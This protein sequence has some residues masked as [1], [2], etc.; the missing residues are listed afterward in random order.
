MA[1]PATPTTRNGTDSETELRTPPANPFYAVQYHFG[2]LL[3]VQDFQDEQGYHR[4]K[5]R[6]HN[7][8]LH[9]EGVVWGMGVSLPRPDDGPL[10]GEIEVAP[11][12]GLDGA[13]QELR[14]ETPM[15]VDV[16]RWF[17]EQAEDEDFEVREREEAWGLAEVAFDAHVLARFRAC[18]TRPVPAMSEPC[19]GASSETAYSRLSETVELVLVPGPPPPPDS[20][21]YHRLRLL[22]ALA[23][24][25]TDEEGIVEA[26]QAVLDARTDILELAPEERPEAFLEALRRFAAL[27]VVDRRPADE[28]GGPSRHFPLGGRPPLLLAS[29]TDL[30]LV[31]EGEDEPWRLRGGEVDNGVR[32]SHVAT[33]TIQELLAGLAACC[34]RTDEEEGAGEGEDGPGNGMPERPGDPERPP[35]LP[36]PR[37]PGDPDAEA[38]D[39]DA[40]G[41]RIDPDSVVLEGRSI[42]FFSTRPLSPRSV[43]DPRS[44]RVSAFDEVDGWTLPGIRRISYNRRKQ[45]VT[46]QLLEAPGDEVRLL[47]IVARGTG[48]TPLL[49]K[50]GIP[51]AGV[52]GGPPGSRHDGHD[53][54][55]MF[56]LEEGG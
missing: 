46:V 24:P 22:F 42:R 48:R 1:D 54:V 15:C 18:A 35:R 29:L 38:D 2:Q 34:G 26:D 30:R 51:L 40:G 12:L 25:R 8:W 3:S 9:G 27:D 11:G 14:L 20:R 23:E 10:R 21:L 47:R 4:G 45:R 44:V 17:H 43:I 33:S 53:F 36:E 41:A 19:E 6:L 50:E 16:V 31:R 7:A 39:G 28:T 49:D 52:S 32:R 56:E 13:G 37:R 55:Y 5:G